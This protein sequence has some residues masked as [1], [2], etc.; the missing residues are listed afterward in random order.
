[1][2]G[3]RFEMKKIIVLDVNLRKNY[4]QIMNILY[5]CKFSIFHAKSSFWNRSDKLRMLSTWPRL[6]IS[7]T[8]L[9]LAQETENGK[10]NLQ[11]LQ[12]GP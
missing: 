8:T 1:M 10:R 12:R 2:G 4:L 3:G 9:A 11:Y 5:Q 6:F 7:H